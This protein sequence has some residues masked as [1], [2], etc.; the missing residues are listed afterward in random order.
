L[1]GGASAG[2]AAVLVASE[3][4]FVTL[5]IAGA[6]YLIYLGVQAL[7]G[8]L[9]GQANVRAA[10]P[11]PSGHEL[12]QGLLSNL[13]NPKMAIFFSSLLPQFGASFAA[14]LALGLLFCALTMIWLSAYAA[15]LARVGDALRR[16]RVRRA[17]DTVTGTA[18]VAMGFRLA[19]ADR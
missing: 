1:G 3:L 4:A 19:A 10:A 9:H 11:A 5:K 6:A 13:G 7:L 18:L 16:P 17:I 12:R 14:L 2:V 15:A 8:S